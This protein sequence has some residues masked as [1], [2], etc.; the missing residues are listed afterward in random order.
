MR[1]SAVSE[2]V[3]IYPS[4]FL[5]SAVYSISSVSGGELFERVAE[6]DC[7]TEKEAA[8][9]MHQLL[10]GLQHMHRKSIVHLD[11]KV[12]ENRALRPKDTPQTLSRLPE[13]RLA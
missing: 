13:A 9:Y 10:Q 11:L 2:F 8:Y 1:N 7:L 3:E 4:I 12:T 6:N 5:D